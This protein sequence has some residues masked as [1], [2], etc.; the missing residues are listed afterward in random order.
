LRA[1][2]R[3]QHDAIEIDRLELK[4]LIG[5]HHRVGGDQPILAAGLQ[6]VAGKTDHCHLRAAGAILKRAQL[7]AHSAD[8][9]VIDDADIGEAGLAQRGLHKARIAARMLSWVE[10]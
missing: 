9:L 6:A 5:A 3:R 7:L 4:V 1:R 8:A 2:H 10:C